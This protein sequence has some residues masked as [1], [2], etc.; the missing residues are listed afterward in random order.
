ML[1]YHVSIGYNDI[2]K[3]FIPRIPQSVGGS[4]NTT[5]KRICFS[6]TVEQCLCAIKDFLETL[7]D[8]ESN[9][10]TI[11]TLD[12]D[13]L[14]ADLVSNDIVK[15]YVHDAFLTG[16]VWVTTPVTLLGEH[17]EI[18]NL[19]CDPVVPI[20]ESYRSTITD[21]I[22]QLIEIGRIG[23]DVLDYLNADNLYTFV[24]YTL[25]NELSHYGLTAT[26]LPTTRRIGENYVYNISLERLN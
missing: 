15:S 21:D 8:S 12:T 13:Q 18:V 11:Y 7:E 4:E 23:T 24:N 25:L 2:E 19:E 9:T 16:E 10:L 22:N 5:I 6:P 20:N 3:Q 1:Y 26:D 14:D 17:Y